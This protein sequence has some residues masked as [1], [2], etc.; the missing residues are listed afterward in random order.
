MLET[1][2]RFG[3]EGASH[4]KWKESCLEAGMSE[5][6]F[7]RGL[8][9]ALKEGMVTKEGEGQGAQYRVVK[10]EAV[11]VSADVKRVS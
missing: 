11:P 7:A 3:P 4:G 9:D 6:K 8:R 5:S 2:E 1:L 10:S